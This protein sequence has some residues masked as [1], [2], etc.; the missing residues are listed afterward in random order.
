MKGGNIMP[1]RISWFKNKRLALQIALG[2]Q[3]SMNV[4]S[5]YGVLEKGERTLHCSITFLDRFSRYV[6]LLCLTLEVFCL[7][8]GNIHETVFLEILIQQVKS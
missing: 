6:K 7:F 1:K 2:M 3:V 5:I 4:E 8:T